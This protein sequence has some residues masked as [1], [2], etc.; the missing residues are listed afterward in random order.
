MDHY[1]F[2][3]LQVSLNA[4][5]ETTL[6]SPSP[7]TLSGSVTMLDG[8]STPNRELEVVI[9][10]TGRVKRTISVVTDIQGDFSWVFRAPSYEK[11]TFTASARHPCQERGTN[12]VNWQVLSMKVQYNALRVSG[13]TF[14]NTPATFE[15]RQILTNDGPVA[16]HDISLSLP[17][18]NLFPDLDSIDVVPESSQTELQA[19]QSLTYSITVTVR[20]PTRMILS[21]G[22]SSQ[23]GTYIIFDLHLTINQI[24][25]VFEINP[26]SIQLNGVRGSIKTVS[27]RITNTGGSEATNVR[28][29]FPDFG[30][31]QLSVV[32]FGPEGLESQGPFV[33]HSN[34][35]AVLV[36][37][38]RIPPDQPFGVGSGSM[39]VSS[40]EGQ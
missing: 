14:T 1:I 38:F 9:D 15:S 5:T 40:N 4:L 33:L 8:S 16:L 28:A 7:V 17:D 39:S 30:A 18:V 31:I 20:R 37:S 29:L 27:L 36:I 2:L 19:D 6:S 13:E 25:P 26:D 22:F 11:G 12:S 10:I 23:E 21:I 34:S 3:E 24:T 32:S 35:S